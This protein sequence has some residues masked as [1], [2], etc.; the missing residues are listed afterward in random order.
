M[1]ENL[2]VPF[3]EHYLHYS[4]INQQGMI[5]GKDHKSALQILVL[6][7]ISISRHFILKKRS[8]PNNHVFNN[9]LPELQTWYNSSRRMI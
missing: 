8:P 1:N 2:Q 6:Y 4:L 5:K 9:F 7:R 3:Y